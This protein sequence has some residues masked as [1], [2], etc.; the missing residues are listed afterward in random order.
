MRYT[1]WLR[2]FKAL[3][4]LLIAFN[5]QAQV[6]FGLGEF[7]RVQRFSGDHGAYSCAYDP[8]GNSYITGYMYD[9]KEMQPMQHWRGV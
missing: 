4:T 6:P 3:G 1:R 8:W 2:A 7:E 5:L 9:S